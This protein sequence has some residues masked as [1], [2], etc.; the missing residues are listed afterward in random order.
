MSFD[1]DNLKLID[2]SSSLDEMVLLLDSTDSETTSPG[3]YTE[4]EDQL[5]QAIYGED[6]YEKGYRNQREMAN[7]FKD[8]LSKASRDNL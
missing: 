3:G 8:I 4:Y 2:F 1:S 6:G 5:D 7:Q